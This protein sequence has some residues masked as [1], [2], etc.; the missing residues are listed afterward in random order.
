MR[1]YPV[2]TI[3]KY[4]EMKMNDGTWKYVRKRDRKRR[5]NTKRKLF[6]TIFLLIVNF[7]FFNISIS[8]S[9]ATVL[10]V[11]YQVDYKKQEF[12]SKLFYEYLKIKRVVDPDFI[13]KQVIWE[14]GWFKSRY[15]T[16]VMINNF[17]GHHYP[18]SRSTTAYGWLWGDP[19][20]INGRK[21]YFKVA[22]YRHWTDFVEDIVLYQKYIRDV[23]GIDLS[24]Y[25][26]AIMLARYNPSK[27]YVLKVNSVDLSRILGDII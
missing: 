7:L 6:V 17:G 3:N 2:G 18:V 23:K 8:I 12:C 1:I 14:T 9:S 26:K 13:M 11:R 19:H 16:D 25:P 24:D 15:A 21:V 5:S 27:L 10:Q 22:K 20:Y 4:G